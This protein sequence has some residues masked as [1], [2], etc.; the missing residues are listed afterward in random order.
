[1]SFRSQPK[2]VWAVAFA[3]VI[4]FMGI[5]LVDPILP[6][7]SR[8][9]DATAGQAML[10]FTSYLFITA[11]AMFFSSWVASRFGTK[12]TLL[13]GLFLVVVF[14]ALAGGSSTVGQ[15]IGFRAGWG[16]GNALFISTALAAIV[17]SAS[18][19]TI[20][21]IM[22]YEAALGVGIAVG[23]LLGGF[24]GAI[25][26][27]GP[28]FGTAALMTIGLASIVILLPA[29]PA[30]APADRVTFSVMFSAFRSAPLMV[31]AAS[32]FLYNY[33]F[34]SLLAWSPFPLERSA[35]AAGIEF[36][37]HEL[38]LV[39]FGW[40]IALAIT[41]VIVAPRLSARYGRTRTLR[42][43][44][45]LL[46][47]DLLGLALLCDSLPGLIVGVVVGGALLGVVNTVMTEAVM[48]A[49]DLPRSVASSTYSC[50]RFFGGAIAS[51]AAGALA[52]AG[53]DGAPY[54]AG[55][56]ALL[57][58]VAVVTVFGRLLRH[59]DRHPDEPV[60]VE[61]MAITAGDA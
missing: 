41:S 46:A 5:G 4:A 22:L 54:L 52:A 36:G 7:I 59:I 3:A 1:M 32:A 48:E 2:S 33:A 30:P 47:L 23:P 24:L 56:A 43:T 8:D 42:G 26:W 12:K 34:F 27:R 14:A 61:A 37:A 40:G 50:L 38:G 9:L 20:G 28:F 31:L 18:G 6:A 35:H 60:Q 13:T 51:W 19:G 55:A 15:I 57:G 58:C 11:I 16:L 29:T 25:S 17:A 39:F 10:L 53:G 45:V 49:T 44:W 21:A